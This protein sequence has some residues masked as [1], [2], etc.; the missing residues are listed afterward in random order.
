MN[1]IRILEVQSLS[2]VALLRAGEGDS[3][4]KEGEKLAMEYIVAE[5]LERYASTVFTSADVNPDVTNDGKTTPPGSKSALLLALRFAGSEKCFRFNWS[6]CT[7]CILNCARPELDI[8]DA[9]R[10][11]LALRNKRSK[12]GYPTVTRMLDR[13]ETK[14]NLLAKIH[15]EKT[16]IAIAGKGDVCASEVSSTKSSISYGRR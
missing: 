3:I 9:A 13:A 12:D 6:P 5:V 4:V 1:T 7:R 10:K 2:V 11:A 8:R 14:N 16:P 15:K